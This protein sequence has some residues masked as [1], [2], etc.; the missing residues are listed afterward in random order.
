MRRVIIVVACLASVAC[1]DTKP[2]G[3]RGSE[4]NAE[5]ITTTAHNY[6]E[7]AVSALENGDRK[8]FVDAMEK[9]TS[10]VE[11]LS[12]EEQ[13]IAKSAAAEWDAANKG[14]KDACFEKA[15]TM[16]SLT[17]QEIESSR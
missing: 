1:I 16:P 9:M 4:T 3:D 5:I 17:P 12:A 11:G 8:G 15:L 14:R 10:W 2:R 6:Q 7:M 13:A